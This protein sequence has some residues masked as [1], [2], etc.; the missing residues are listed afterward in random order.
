MRKDIPKNLLI[1]IVQYKL[2][3]FWAT[4]NPCKEAQE[5]RLRSYMELRNAILNRKDIEWQN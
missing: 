4:K 3:E 5:H 1:A 2:A